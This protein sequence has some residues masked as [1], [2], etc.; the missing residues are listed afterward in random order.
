MTYVHEYKTRKRLFAVSPPTAAPGARGATG[1]DEKPSF[2]LIR[3]ES[4]RA[5]PKENV[6]IH[7][8]RLHQQRIGI[9]RR[10]DGVAMDHSN[11]EA[12]IRD[13]LSKWSSCP[14][15]GSLAWCTILMRRSIC[16]WLRVGLY[17]KCF[18]IKVAADCMNLGRDA[19][20][21]IVG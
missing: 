13:C 1:I 6:H 2:E 5:S 19:A 14:D 8:S 20:E 21:E 10:D 3:L 16:M 12:A 9:A 15:R 11:L 4:V 7:L 18:D 17:W